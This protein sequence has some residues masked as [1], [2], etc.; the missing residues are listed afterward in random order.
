MRQRA[1]QLHQVAT[2]LPALQLLPQ[3]VKA[4]KREKETRKRTKIE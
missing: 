3:K 1:H 4:R 2:M